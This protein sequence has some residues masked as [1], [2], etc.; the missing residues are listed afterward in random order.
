MLII[1]IL[2]GVAIY[3]YNKN[4]SG[5]GLVA[6]NPKSDKIT[7]QDLKNEYGATGE[8][9]L[10]QVS[11]EFDGRKILAVK[12]EIEFNVA[13]AGMLNTD[14]PTL[15]NF[16]SIV[17]NAPSKNGVW[18]NDRSKDT[19]VKMIN[20]LTEGEYFVDNDGYLSVK[21][22]G[23]NNYDK[24]IIKLINGEKIIFVDISGNNYIVD[25]MSGQIE[26]NPFEEMDPYQSYEYYTYDNKMVVILTTNKEKILTN[27]EIID[28]FLTLVM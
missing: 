28:D 26:E 16:N 23:N 5:K 18:I 25:P 27:K 3:F 20:E 13:L 8:N 10:Y 2:V 14:K 24:N 1:L 19:F 21:S 11:E 4:K 9:D 12:P 15:E 6:E 17:N 7:V 22:E